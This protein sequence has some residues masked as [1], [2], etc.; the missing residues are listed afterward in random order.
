MGP[1][2]F[3]KKNAKR[4]ILRRQIHQ[5]STTMSI[6][7]AC[8]VDDFFGF[9]L[10]VV[11]IQV[12]TLDIWN[13]NIRIKKTA[14]VCQTEL[15]T[16]ISFIVFSNVFC[17]FGPLKKNG[18]FQRPKKRLWKAPEHLLHLM[19]GDKIV[20]QVLPSGRQLENLIKTYKNLGKLRIHLKSSFLIQFSN[21]L[22]KCSATA[23]LPP[24]RCEATPP[25]A[26]GV[27]SSWGTGKDGVGKEKHERNTYH[28]VSSYVD[29]V[30]N[31]INYIW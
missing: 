31:L 24:R 10:P 26:R 28:L 29:I 3:Q 1:F 2:L 4:R 6:Q 23:Q 5:T 9:L 7:L 16:P 25:T 18:P 19:G 30:G 8:R 14:K 11:W 27:I 17:S 21:W 15:K 13:V 22:T 20:L 12:M